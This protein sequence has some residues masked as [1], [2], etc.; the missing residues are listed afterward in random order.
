[1]YLSVIHF[2]N[3]CFNFVGKKKKSKEEDK[4][5]KRRGR[6]ST[7]SEL[8]GELGEGSGLAEQLEG[9]DESGRRLVKEALLH[10]LGK[11]RHRTVVDGSESSSEEHEEASGMMFPNLKKPHKTDLR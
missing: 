11:P 9:L 7:L 8:A 5:R 10:K 6:K 3:L 1:M 2:S 4:R